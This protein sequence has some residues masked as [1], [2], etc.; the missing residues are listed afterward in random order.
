[1]RYNADHEA[2]ALVLHRLLSCTPLPCVAQDLLEF[3]H[4]DFPSEVLMAAPKPRK[5]TMPSKTPKAKSS[6]DENDGDRNAADDDEASDRD[7][8]VPSPRS[9]FLLT[10]FQATLRVITSKHLLSASCQRTLSCCDTACLALV[11]N[12]SRPNRP[13]IPWMFPR[14]ES[15]LRVES[16]F[17]LSPKQRTNFQH[18]ARRCTISLRLALPRK[19]LPKL[20]LPKNWL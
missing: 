2:R 4:D 6:S 18:K 13:S 11:M 16:E 20:R 10:L 12:Y 5:L 14:M 15:S 9:T 3:C 17:V 1:M 8:E 19:L 7:H